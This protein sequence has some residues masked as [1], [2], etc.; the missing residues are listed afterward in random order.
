MGSAGGGVCSV[1][2]DVLFEDGADVVR[3]GV[4]A[5]LESV[6]SG[7]GVSVGDGF[8][9]GG[10]GGGFPCGGGSQG[11]G[12]ITLDKTGVSLT[13]DTTVLFTVTLPSRYVLLAFTN[14]EPFRLPVGDIIEVFV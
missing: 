8:S 13:V 4:T 11:L 5:I 14:W 12:A 9:G 10:S 7:G 6:S 3:N 2:S 1:A